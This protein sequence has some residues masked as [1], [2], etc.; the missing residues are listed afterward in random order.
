[1]KLFKTV[2]HK[3]ADIGFVKVREDK[4]GV[5]Y[6]RV[7]KEF[8]YTQC[9]NILHKHSG[10]HILQSYDKELFDNKGIGNT[11]VGLTTYELKLFYKK[12]SYLL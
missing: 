3:L 2:D 7:N 10:K 11:C 6:E 5:E 9:V 1:M 12:M 4:H 8:G